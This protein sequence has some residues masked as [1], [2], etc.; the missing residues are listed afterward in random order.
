MFDF[1]FDIHSFGPLGWLGLL[2]WLASLGVGAYLYSVWRERNPVRA[3]FFRQLGLGMSILGAVGVVLLALKALQLPY[4]GWPIWSYLAAL[5]TLGYL[6]WAGWFY[7]SRLPQLLAA[8]GRSATR[9]GQ[10]AKTYPAARSGRGA[11]TYA[12]PAARGSNGARPAEAPPAT[13]PRPV[14]TTGRREARRD[15]KR[16][17]R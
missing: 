8:A 6:A 14:A 7:S 1:L 13:P 2:G 12:A 15:R 5:A 3:R 10:G 9:T 16:K 11:K 4:V 17:S